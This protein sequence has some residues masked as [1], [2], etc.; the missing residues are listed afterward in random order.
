[1]VAHS[2]RRS[3][4][5]YSPTNRYVSQ[6]YPSLSS[7]DRLITPGA[8]Q[9]EYLYL[10]RIDETLLRGNHVEI[11]DCLTIYQF[12]PTISAVP[13]PN[14]GGTTV[15][16]QNSIHSGPQPEGP[17]SGTNETQICNSR[18]D[19][20]LM[21]ASGTKTP[22]SGKLLSQIQSVSRYSRSR[23]EAKGDAVEPKRRNSLPSNPYDMRNFAEILLPNF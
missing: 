4:I 20:Q 3:S 6:R 22:M 8:P 1:M 21:E 13:S 15:I 17:P 5:S 7:P 16:Q 9:K 10:S 18:A 19:S 12:S 11:K 14:G 2:S 23:L